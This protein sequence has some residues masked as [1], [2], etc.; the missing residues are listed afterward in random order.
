MRKCRTCQQE[1]QNHEFDLRPPDKKG[2]QY[3]RSDCKACRKASLKQ[4]KSQWDNSEKGKQY[5]ADYQRRYQQRL[6]ELAE[7]GKQALKGQKGIT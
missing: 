5:K 6:R 1:K 4:F 7:I 2:N 3:F